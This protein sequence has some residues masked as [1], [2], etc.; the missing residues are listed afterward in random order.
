[1][2]P[3]DQTTFGTPGGN[4]FSACVASLLELSI[5]D[6]P[7]FMGDTKEEGEEWLERFE[8]W[9]APLGLYPLMFKCGDHRPEGLHIL[10][11]KTSRGDHGVVARGSDMIHDPH[12]SR[13]GLLSH[14][15]CV[16]LVSIDPARELN[17]EDRVDEM[18]AVSSRAF[19]V[20]CDSATEDCVGC[21][22]GGGTNKNCAVCTAVA[23]LALIA[24]PL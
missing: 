7:Y 23:H 10:C 3:V 22:C 2:K 16:V 19:E 18:R 13:I 6:V 12:P 1:M 8:E 5:E 9:L 24:D 20:L 15:H 21:G 14:N 11:G 4:C 17:A